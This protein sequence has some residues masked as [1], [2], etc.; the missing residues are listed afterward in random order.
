MT[1]KKKIKIVGCKN[2]DFY[3]LS[4]LQEKYDTENVRYNKIVINIR[5]YGVIKDATLVAITVP[6]VWIIIRQA[7]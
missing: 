6:Q 3:T 5:R 4:S 1:E 7:L 2:L